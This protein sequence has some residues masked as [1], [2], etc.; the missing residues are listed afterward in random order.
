LQ[1]WIIP[2]SAVQ[3]RDSSL[4]NPSIAVASTSSTSAAKPPPPAVPKPTTTTAAAATPKA[5]KNPVIKAGLKGV[6]VTKKRTRPDVKPT[7]NK[8]HSG[9]A[10]NEDMSTGAPGK[11]KGKDDDDTEDGSDR[12]RR[13]VE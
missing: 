7:D 5:K 10:E 13:R 1:L 8:T 4:S 2:S 9:K 11:E 12:K 6:I 3:A